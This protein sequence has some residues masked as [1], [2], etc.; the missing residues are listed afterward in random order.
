MKAD[1]GGLFGLVI[2]SPILSLIILSNISLLHCSVY[3]FSS[4]VF[5]GRIYCRGTIVALEVITACDISLPLFLMG[6]RNHPRHYFAA[7]NEFGVL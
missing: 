1:G 6:P 4:D 5:R 3:E 7:G 2:A